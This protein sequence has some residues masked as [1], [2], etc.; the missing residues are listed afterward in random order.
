M[1]HT[2]FDGVTRNYAATAQ[3][4]YKNSYRRRLMDRCILD[5]ICNGNPENVKSFLGVGK[6]AEVELYIPGTVKIRDTKPDG[7][8]VYQQL[9]DTYETFGI[10]EESYWA[11]K[12][13]P[14]DTKFM[15]FDPKSDTLT[16]AADMMARHMEKK[17]GAKM[18]GLVPAYNRGHNAGATW[19]SYDLGA[20]TS[21]DAVVLYKTQAQ[22]D[23]ATS[24]EHRDVAADFIV[25]LANTIRQNEGL[26]GGHV[27]VIFP[28]T[29]KHHLMTSEL[30]LGGLMGQ[31]NVDLGSGE[32]GGRSEVRFLG[33]MDDTISVIQ[34]NIMFRESAFTYESSGKRHTVYPIFAMMSD[35]VAFVHDTIL[36]ENALKDVGSWDEHYRAKEVYDFP[37]LFPQMMAMAYV[38]LAEP[39]YTAST[40]G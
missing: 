3:K 21:G 35:A 12:F 10:N 33:T 25:K 9:T 30:K 14:E 15:P 32:R 36:R 4:R 37:V 23:A 17:F 31:R 29:V 39:A 34:N 28:D 27:T 13:R 26:S 7:G 5:D 38:E 2:L 18:P 24:V 6:G 11:V 40:G 20:P 8:I 16:N 22:C 1:A 19:G